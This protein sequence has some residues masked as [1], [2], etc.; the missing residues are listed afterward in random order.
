M[1]YQIDDDRG[2]FV[3]KYTNSATGNHDSIRFGLE[4]VTPLNQADMDRLSNVFRDNLKVMVDSGWSIGP[5]SLLYQ[6]VGL[7]L[8]L[9]NTATEAGTATAAV[10]SPDNVSVI[11]SKKS[12]FAGRSG[13]GRVYFPPVPES[14]VDEAGQLDSTYVSDL[15]TQATTLL[16]AVN[17]DASVVNMVIL[18]EEGSTLANYTVASLLVR[19][20]IGTV[21]KRIRR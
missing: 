17:A 4:L 8:T 12:L 14:L 21:R 3:V 2:L 18:H 5:C 20:T 19:N 11:I 6:T 10:Y 9:E 16:G 7:R 15:Q 13:R 1:P